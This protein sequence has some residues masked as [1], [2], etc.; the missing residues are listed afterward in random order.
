MPAPSNTI[1]NSV[2]SQANGIVSFA[3]ARTLIVDQFVSQL[4]GSIAGLQA[5][6]IT[7]TF[8]TVSAAPS[9]EVPDVPAFQTPIWVSPN[10]PAAFTEALDVSDLTIEPFDDAPPVIT[11]G[12]APAPFSAVMP[13]AP[14]INL[15]FDDPTL[16]VN[17]PA[18]PNLL[19]ISV[20][21]FDGMTMPTFDA[22]EPVLVEVAPTIREYT[23]GADYTSSLLTELQV[24]LLE[25]IQN[26]GTGIGDAEQAIWERGRER[27]AR[28]QQDA[29]LKLEQMEGLGYA[30][31]PGF[32]LDARQRI[33]TETDYAER[34]HSREVMVK[35]AELQLE[36]VKH[37]LTTAV[38]LESRQMD[39]TNA[40]EQRLFES[41]R[42]ATEAGIAIYNARVQAFGA[43]VDIYRAKVGA[44]E[45]LVRAET[46]KVEA[47]KAEI[48]AEEAKARVNQALVEQY[49]VQVD[50][51]LSAIKIYEAQIGGIQAKAEIEKTKVMVFGEQ[52]RGYSAQVNAYTAGV[53]G[54]RAS[55]QAES[56]KAQ[57][58]QAQV[59]AFS[60]RVNAGTRQIEARIAAY[61]GR[62]DAKSAELEGYRAAVQGETARIQ[63][64][65][66]QN[67]VLSESFRAQVTAVA[68]Y[69]DTLTKQWQAI[70][71]QNQRVAEI[72]ISSAKANAELFVTTRSLAL[73]AA[74]AGATVQAQIGAAAINAFNFSGSVSASEG[75]QANESVSNSS[76][77]VKSTSDSTSTNT[78]YNYSV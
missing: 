44:Y 66:S 47:Y 8:P 50:A 9:L 48:S 39:Y 67:T 36:N 5:P 30:A 21:Q 52:V 16:S 35:S 3:H 14:A 70:L 31:P 25:R 42:Y 53:E 60:A 23:P 43:M 54:F 73:D 78:N 18:V 72:G 56:T 63:G 74:K 46:A 41:T 6:P 59:D 27:E 28:A 33:I 32:Y 2:M 71:D 34:G 51:A 7:A 4:A 22:E 76:S 58:Y 15:T 61:K 20:R 45:A 12:S 11:Y 24:T 75:Y 38:Q 29:I 1:A 13:D 69:N 37:A 17:L 62:I 55:L 26:G 64:I 77:T 49:R 40:V 68:S 10:P 57:V 19:T 65:T